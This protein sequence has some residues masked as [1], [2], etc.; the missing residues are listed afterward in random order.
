MGNTTRYQCVIV[1]LCLDYKYTASLTILLISFE[2]G[3]FQK[4]LEGKMLKKLL[5][6]SSFFKCIIDPGNVYKNFTHE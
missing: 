4:Y 2:T 5:I 1:N 6:N 3:T